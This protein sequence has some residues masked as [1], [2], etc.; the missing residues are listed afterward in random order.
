LGIAGTSGYRVYAW[1]HNGAAVSGWPRTTA[2]NMPATPA[3]ADLNGDMILD[4]IIGCGAESDQACKNLYAWEGD[5]SNLPGF[6]MQ[7]LSGTNGQRAQPYSSVVADIDNDDQPEI[8]QTMASTTAL[9]II[10]HTGSQSSDL[11]RSL[12]ANS[13][14]ILAS[15]LIADVDNDGLLET[16]IGAE[17]NG[18]AA[19]YIFEEVGADDLN[20][21]PWPAFQFNM[22]RS[23][24]ISPPVLEATNNLYAFHQQGSGSTVSIQTPLKNLG[25]GEIDWTLTESIAAVTPA[26]TSGTFVT[27]TTIDLTI[28]TTGLAANQWHN[29][30]TITVSGTANGSPVAG[31]PQTITINL[32]KGDV[33]FIY[34]PTVT[35]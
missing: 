21:R 30:G 5:G 24:A 25:G 4:V 33:S 31:N 14:T 17:N 9:R 19:V 16:V 12:Q 8:V 28:N 2:G 23:G 7:P 13:N 22:L 10:E 29:L 20:S 11:S 15:P 32:Y 1:H 27:Q 18:Q 34:L 3:L 35:K 6:P 26:A